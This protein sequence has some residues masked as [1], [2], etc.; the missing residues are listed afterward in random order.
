[1]EKNNRKYSNKDITVYWRPSECVH[2]SICYTKLLEVFNP[3]NKPWV[4]MEGAST[5]KIIDIV[6]ECPTSALTFKWN[7]TEKNRLEKSPKSIKEDDLTFEGKF[8]EEPVKIQIMKNGPIL[9]SGKFKIE[10]EDGNSIKSMQIASL[11]RCGN[12][13]NHPYCD[14]THFKVGFK[15]QED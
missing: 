11:C 5:D 8:G 4:N 13:G 1:M 7:D 6:N 15:D 9:V 2:A 3:R 14:G 10:G 12:T